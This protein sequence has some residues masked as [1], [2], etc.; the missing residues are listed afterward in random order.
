MRIIDL[1]QVADDA[2]LDTHVLA[3]D[4][5]SQ[6]LKI[7][8][9][10]LK[11][12]LGDGFVNVEGDEM[13]GPLRIDFDFRPLELRNV[14]PGE[15]CQIAARK[16]DGA[17]RWLLGNDET[18]GDRA[19]FYNNIGTCGIQLL[20]NGHVNVIPAPGRSFIVTQNDAALLLQNITTGFPLFFQGLD[21]QGVP[22]W[23]IGNIT[24]GDEMLSISS[25]MGG[26]HLDTADGKA[27]AVRTYVDVQ[28]QYGAGAYNEQD[29]T[30][31]PYFH[32]FSGNNAGNYRPLWKIR[33]NLQGRTWSGGALD[34]SGD[35][36]INFMRTDDTGSFFT[37]VGSSGMLLLGNYENFDDRYVN[38]VR[39][40]SYMVGDAVYDSQHRVLTGVYHTNG[41]QEAPTEES[42]I[43]QFAINDAWYDAAYV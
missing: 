43:L 18:G 16:E 38:G 19:T 21:A 39:L 7:T 9:G 37:F 22:R 14:S 28:G 36:V 32:S 30:A 6:T 26:I 40:A 20:G 35:F 41:Y 10:Q 29:S 15:Q 8:V 25:R 3:I 33:D 5:P 11:A 34:D 24:N 1:T 4:D 31:A 27:V 12:F 42:R 23:T 17:E 13:T 2:I